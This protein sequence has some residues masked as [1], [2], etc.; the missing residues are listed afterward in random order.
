MLVQLLN[1]IQRL[2]TKEAQFAQYNLG[3]IYRMGDG[4]SQ[5]AETSVM[6]Y[7]KAAITRICQ[8][9]N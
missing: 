8:R 9:S 3:K 7:K 4:V 1:G 5:D 2:Q 6:W